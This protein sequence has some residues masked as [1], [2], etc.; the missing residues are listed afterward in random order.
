YYYTACRLKLLL[1]VA[2]EEAIQFI[3][4]CNNAPRIELM[5]YHLAKYY[6]LK[7]DF[8]SAIRFYEKAGLTHLSNEEVADA[9]FEKAYCYFNLKKFNE[10]K[11]LFNEIHQL[12]SNKYYIP[13]NYYFGFISYFQHDFQTALKC[14]RLIETRDEYKGV[15]P[16]YIAEI[17]YFQQKKEE[18][19]RYAES[20]LSRGGLYYEKELKL[21]VGQIYFEK[22]NFSKA[23]PLLE[24]YASNSE[25]I[26]REVL[27]ELSYSYYENGKVTQAIEGL[28]Q[29]SNEKDSLGQNSMYLLADCYLKTNQK[30]NARAAFQFCAANNSNLKQQEI[31]RFHYAKLSYELG[32]QDLALSDMR[33]FALQYPQSAYL[34]EARELMVSMLANTNNFED[35]LTLYHSFEKPTPTMLKVYPRILFG[36]AVSYLNDQ[37]LTKADSLFTKILSLANSVVTPYTQFWKGEIA[38]REARYD[39]ALKFITSF[40]QSNVPASGEA[41]YSNA[42]YLLGYSWLKKEQYKQAL[43]FFEPIGK[44]SITATALEQDAFVRTADCYFMIKDFSKANALYDQVINNALPQS[45]YAMF[46]KAMIA[47]VKSSSTKI[48]LLNTLA[49]QYPNSSIVGDAWMEIANAL[50]ADEQFDAA[51]PYLTKIIEH[52]A[53][54]GLKPKALLK[55][56]LCLYNLDKN[57]AALV[58]YKQ[59]IQ[60]FPQSPEAQEALANIRSIYIEQGNPDEYVTLMNQNGIQVSVSEADSITF[61]AAELRY[62]SNDCNGAIQGFTNY[63]NKYPAGSFSLEANFFAAECYVKNQNF[64]KAVEHYGKVNERGLN[65]YFER[66][67][68]AAARTS[69]LELKDYAGAK[70]YFLS[71]KA[72]AVSQE[73]QL[74]AARGLVRCF[75]QLKDYEQANE[76]AKDLLARKGISTD[77]KSIGWLVLGKS[78]QNAK[79]FTGAI[80]AFKSCAAINKSAWGAEAR[81]GIALSQFQLNNMV[82]AEKAAQTVIRE[83]NGYDYWVTSAYILLGDIYLNAGDYFNAK[84]TYQSVAEHAIITELKTSAQEKLDNA[85]AAEKQVSKV[86]SN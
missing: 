29:L 75:Y 76:I 51:L 65:R 38:Y 2:E 20:V 59:L 26:S 57:A 33:Q 47:G 35:A 77:D 62:T 17:Y 52:P 19:L 50:M 7:D 12:P 30:S 45:D 28:K 56:G 32:Y 34:P 3:D 8:N 39:E 61:T 69:Y 73:N 46:Q 55:S 80:S 82:A 18:A 6:F 36:R 67:T 74:E 10:A 63:L 83:T 16:Y 22:K 58:S 23:L 4:W 41:N 78:L 44:N 21:L 42:R 49:R 5:S 79:D 48:S 1:P 14:F 85:I 86:Q 11:P 53:S 66:A 15:V 43:I 64:A 68:L 84:A 31:S 60:Q 40:Q 24:F 13:A 71:L 81:Y 27:Y 72:G 37:Q 9:K 54:G 25:K 70:K